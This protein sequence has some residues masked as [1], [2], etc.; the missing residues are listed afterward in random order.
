[1]PE[2][3]A[4]LT[5]IL[6]I[7]MVITRI[8]LLK[9]RDIEAMQFGKTHRTDFL[10]PPFVLFY[11]YLIFANAF[12]LPTLT[13]EHIFQSDLIA[14]L[15]VLCC[16][17]G[18]ALLAASLVSFGRSFRVGIDAEHP[19]RL[20]TGGAFALTRNP[21]YVAFLSVLLGQFLVFPNL[22]FL[23]YLVAAFL[24]IHRQIVR[25]EDFMKGHYG[26]EYAD[27]C[28]RVRRYL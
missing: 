17:A 16:L 14:W 10:L 18:M 15:G 4:A 27:Y 8:I 23:V 2:I 22:I 6:L 19:D 24:V 13:R 7:A 12:N 25:E 3:L 26:Q 21:I 20:V 11:F 28:R 9:R 1:M 5:I